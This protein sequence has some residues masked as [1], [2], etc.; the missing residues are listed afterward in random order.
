[1]ATIANPSATLWR[2]PLVDRPVDD[3][4]VQSYPVSTVRA[5][6]PRFAAERPSFILRPAGLATAC[7]I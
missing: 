4:D 6:A 5:L 7:G 1:M 2:V 3:R